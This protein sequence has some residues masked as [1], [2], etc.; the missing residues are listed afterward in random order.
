[1]GAVSNEH[2]EWCHWDISQ[3]EKKNSGKL[4]PNM[5]TLSAENKKQKK[6]K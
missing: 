1:M 2:S 6:M 4:S 5:E 3:T